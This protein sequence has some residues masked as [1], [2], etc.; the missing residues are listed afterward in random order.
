MMGLNKWYK[1]GVYM[2]DLKNVKE[3][4]VWKKDV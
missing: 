4:K 3:K 2:D 1:Q